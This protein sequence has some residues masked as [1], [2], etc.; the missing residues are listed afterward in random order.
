MK[1]VT[2]VGRNQ[3]T[4]VGGDPTANG[5]YFGRADLDCPQCQGGGEI[6]KGLIVNG[7]FTNLTIERCWC[8]GRVTA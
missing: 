4:I 7:K 3:L 1:N 8:V 2:Y 5:T 6:Q